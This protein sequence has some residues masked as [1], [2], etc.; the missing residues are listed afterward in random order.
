MGA[1]SPSDVYWESKTVADVLKLIRDVPM[2]PSSPELVTTDADIAAFP[3]FSEALGNFMSMGVVTFA[4]GRMRSYRLDMTI[5][6][7][8]EILKEV[9]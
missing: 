9:A 2:Y 8:P 5:I 1:G 7:M 4:L 3:P 6:T